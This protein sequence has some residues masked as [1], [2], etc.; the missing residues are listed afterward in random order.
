MAKDRDGALAGGMRATRTVGQKT[1]KTAVRCSGIG[2]HS[3]QPVHMTLAPGEV[4]SGIVFIRGDAPSGH[5]VIPAAWDRVRD[6]NHCTVIS[7]AHGVSVGTIE[8]LMA[9]LY[10]CGID[11]ASIILDGPEVPVMDGSAEPF[12]FLIECAGTTT[13]A[14]ARRAIRVLKQVEVSDSGR[15]A[16]A[17]LSPGAGVSF[18]FELDFAAQGVAPQEGYIRLA[19][20]AFKSDLARAR[21]FGFLAEVEHLRAH[22][23]ARGGSLDNAVVIGDG[24]VLNQD[25]LRYDDEFVRHKILDSVG[26]LYLAGA[27]ILGHFHGC[28]SGHTLNN[29]LLRALFADESAW[30]YDAMDLDPSHGGWLAGPLARSA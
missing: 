14:A 29:R 27:P 4:N 28:R 15:G 12:V 13:Q 17:S 30:C 7:N 3:G 10:G 24:I 2:L 20:G 9:A 21:T 19:N 6:T 23:L 16:S 8:H 5:R 18:S 22:G 25:G 1:L 11:N 26:D